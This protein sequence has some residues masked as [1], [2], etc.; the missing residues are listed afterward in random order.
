M[1]HGGEIR[2]VLN[3]DY[4]KTVGFF[5]AAKM[6]FIYVVSW[7]EKLPMLVFFKTEHDAE[8]KMYFLDSENKILYYPVPVVPGNTDNVDYR[9]CPE[10]Q[11]KQL[12]FITTFEM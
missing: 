2:F 6:N 10:R 5:G 4:E 9:A 7:G 8:I 11:L 12:Y 3:V 1:E